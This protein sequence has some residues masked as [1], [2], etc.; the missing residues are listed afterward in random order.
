M[1][2]SANFT[3]GP[4]TYCWITTFINALNPFDLF[5]KEVSPRA[6][7]VLLLH[8]LNLRNDEMVKIVFACTRYIEEDCSELMDHF[9][10]GEHR[11]MRVA[12]NKARDQ[13]LKRQLMAH[14]EDDKDLGP[15]I[16]KEREKLEKAGVPV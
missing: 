13:G 10:T 15:S 5:L 4:G 7:K 14:F 9:C 8:L 3:G 6:V 1:R 2:K 16:E 11:S 12:C